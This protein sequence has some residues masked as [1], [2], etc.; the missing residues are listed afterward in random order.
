MNQINNEGNLFESCN[1]NRETGRS[2]DSMNDKRKS[3]LGKQLVKML[4]GLTRCLTV[5]RVIDAPKATRDRNMWKVTTN[6]RK[7]GT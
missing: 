6:T 2:F 3:Q 4:D 5:G 7:H 1:D